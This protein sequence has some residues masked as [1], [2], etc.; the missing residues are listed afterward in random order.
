LS[1]KP[2]GV[3]A[4]PPCDALKPI[5]AVPP[6]AR[7]PFHAA[8]VTVT[9]VPDWDHVPP[10]PCVTLT[11]AGAVNVSLQDVSVLPVLVRRTEP[12]RPELQELAV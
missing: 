1:A 3:P 11:P 7:L 8:F 5:S 6:A 10:Q 9:A 2:L 12:D 4:V